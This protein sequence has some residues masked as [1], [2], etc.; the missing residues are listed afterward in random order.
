MKIYF[1]DLDFHIPDNDIQYFNLLESIINTIDELSILE[2]RR[3][4]TK[5]IFRVAPTSPN[6]IT[7][8]IEELNNFHNMLNI[9]VEYSKSIKSSSSLGFNISLT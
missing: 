6:Y 5:Y 3:S 9:K 7:P 4:P 2:V 8:L 1:K